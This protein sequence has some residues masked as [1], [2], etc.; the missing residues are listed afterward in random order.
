MDICLCFRTWFVWSLWV[1]GYRVRERY[2]FSRSM[3]L[4]RPVRETAPGGFSKR[5]EKPEL[6]AGKE[7]ATSHTRAQ[8]A[9][10]LGTNR[11]HRAQEME[12][13]PA[14]NSA[15]VDPVKVLLHGSL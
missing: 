4:P 8:T 13:A 14:Y 2:R 10:W 11:I 3:A 9:L 6:M 7:P 5:I 1:V 15:E 12:R